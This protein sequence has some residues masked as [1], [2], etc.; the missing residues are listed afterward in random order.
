M[1][2]PQGDFP[3]PNFY[4]LFSLFLSFHVPPSDI[5]CVNIF[6][7]SL[8]PILLQSPQKMEFELLSL[9]S[10]IK[11]AACIVGASLTLIE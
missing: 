8:C 4:S 10:R 3:W 9:T 6:V 7:S 2:P 11:P 1:L 5:L